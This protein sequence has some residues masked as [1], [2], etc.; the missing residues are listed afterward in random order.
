[1]NLTDMTQA[2]TRTRTTRNI[3]RVLGQGSSAPPEMKA[4]QPKKAMK[5]RVAKPGKAVM[6]VMKK[7]MKKKKKA[8]KP[9]KKKAMKKKKATII[10][11]GKSACRQVFSGRKVKTMGGLKATD[12]IKNGAGKI[13]TKKAS[14]RGKKNTW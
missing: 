2:N 12:L 8:M 7:A 11:K 3:R 9:M 4:V 5:I 13:V 6:K 10:A 14:D 1:M